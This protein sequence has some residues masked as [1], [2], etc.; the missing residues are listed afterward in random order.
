MS[1][2]ICIAHK[3]HLGKMEFNGVASVDDIVCAVVHQLVLRIAYRRRQQLSPTQT[4]ITTTTTTKVS[5]P[6]LV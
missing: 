4:M 3:L 2:T 1:S 6:T 5:G